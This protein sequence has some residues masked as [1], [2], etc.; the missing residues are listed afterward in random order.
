MNKFRYI[1]VDYAGDSLIDLLDG[2]GSEGWELVSIRHMMRFS[3]GKEY[4]N[5]IFKR[6]LQEQTTDGGSKG[7]S[8][9]SS[10]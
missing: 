2:Y 5:L 6:C 7:S 4:K 8:P 3:D 1:E 9:E 10:Y